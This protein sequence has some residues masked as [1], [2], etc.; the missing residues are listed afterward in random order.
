MKTIL[1]TDDD[2]FLTSMYKLTLEKIGA[3]IIVAHDG[4][5]A[6]KMIGGKKPDLLILDLLMPKMDGFAVLQ[7]LKEQGGAMFPII[8]LSNLREQMDQQKCHE[9]GARDFFCK[10]EMDLEELAEKVKKYL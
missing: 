2:E 9:M 1:I 3:E 8:I 5:Q 7:K 6:L 10:S 4:E